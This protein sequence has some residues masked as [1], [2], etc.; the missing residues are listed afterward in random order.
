MTPNLNSLVSSILARCLSDSDF[1]H[2]LS[3]TPQSILA[4][5]A[6]NDDLIHQFSNLDHRAIECFG[7]LITQTQHNFLWESYPY[8]KALM[9]RYAADLVIFTDYRQALSSKA[10]V[11]LTREQKIDRFVDFLD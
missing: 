8:T 3:A 7:G 4:K 5:F 9:K 6:L 2:T 10:P 11:K 1:R